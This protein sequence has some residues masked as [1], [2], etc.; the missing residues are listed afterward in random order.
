M[1]TLFASIPT[2]GLRRMLACLAST[3]A[4]GVADAGFKVAE[5]ADTV[6]SRF[7]EAAEGLLDSSPD[8]TSP[9]MQPRAMGHL[10]R[11]RGEIDAVSLRLITPGRPRLVWLE[12]AMADRGLAPGSSIEQ[13][14]AA[15]AAALELLAAV[16]PDDPAVRLDRIVGEITADQRDGVEQSSL[17]ANDLAHRPFVASPDAICDRLARSRGVPAAVAMLDLADAAALP[18]VVAA[19]LAAGLDADPAVMERLDR[20]DHGSNGIGPTVIF[21]L[22]RRGAGDAVATAGPVQVRACGLLPFPV[23]LKR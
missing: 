5:S 4:V 7:V 11:L 1:R 18:P 17:M 9:L 2:A 23:Q 22:A 12:A 14:R 6:Q 3:M 16:D 19:V 8:A 15:T 21:E 10:A 13:A 20:L